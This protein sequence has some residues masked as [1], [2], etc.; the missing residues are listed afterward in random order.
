MLAAFATFWLA[1]YLVVALRIAPLL[2][3]REGTGAA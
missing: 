3:A 2:R 1:D